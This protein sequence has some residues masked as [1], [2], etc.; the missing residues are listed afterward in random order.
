MPRKRRELPWMDLRGETYYAFWYDERSGRTERLSL[1]TSDPEQAKRRFAAFLIEGATVYAAGQAQSANGLTCG[2]ALDDYFDEHVKP[3]ADAATGE[4][5]VVDKDRIADAIANLKSYFGDKVVTWVD[6]PKAKE[7]HRLRRAGVIGGKTRGRD[8]KVRPGSN[9]TV[10]RELGVLTAAFNHEVRHKRL[11]VDDVPFV[12]KPAPP[13]P[14]ALWLFPDELAKLRAVCTG[15]VRKWL[16][17]AYYT[18]ARRRSVERL[19]KFQV[20]REQRRINLN[21]AGV[22]QTKKRRPIVPIPDE[23]APTISQCFADSKTEFLLDHPG[24]VRTALNTAA[25]AAGLLDLPARD[26]R[27]AGRF[28]AHVIRHTRATHLLQ[29]GAEPWAVAN[30]LG[31]TLTTVIRVYGHHC[32]SYL[33]G[34]LRP[35]KD[36]GLKEML[37]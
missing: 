26:T 28:T 1:R 20:D 33:E 9:G 31:D 23:L 21:K 10:R 4:S 30:L 37:E 3:G 35:M 34:A 5:E 36:P 29:S 2:Q 22:R 13:P 17:I 32:P 11:K 15:R 8:P 18:A 24:S 16:E 19:T 25:R 14:K 6:I 12:W 27:P 7:Y